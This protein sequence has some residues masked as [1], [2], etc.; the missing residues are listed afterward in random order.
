MKITK[1]KLKQIIKE[2]ISELSDNLYADY[3]DDPIEA[4]KL[5]Q[6]EIMAK[7]DPKSPGS[8]GQDEIGELNSLRK[9][10]ARLEK[11]DEG[12]YPEEGGPADW[13]WAGYE[14]DPAGPAGPSRDRDEPYGGDVVRR[15]DAAT[16]KKYG[17]RRHN[18]YKEEKMK[19]TKSQLKKIIK[20]ELSK[21]VE[22]AEDEDPAIMELLGHLEIVAGQ[23]AAVATDGS[24][25]EDALSIVRRVFGGGEAIDQGPQRSN[26]EDI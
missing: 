19:I 25:L 14:D 10:I 1:S 2:E 24:V 6:Q 22:T 26:R 3:S 5:R 20:E 16:R 12:D 17:R 7:L 23:L 8:F 18:I 4:R 9:E 21:M 11:M 15:D 13:G